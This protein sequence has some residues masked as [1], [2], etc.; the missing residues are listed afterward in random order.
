MVEHFDLDNEEVGGRTIAAIHRAAAEGPIAISCTRARFR[1]RVALQGVTLTQF[2]ASHAIWEKGLHLSQC[3]L[4]GDTRLNGVRA[5]HLEVFDSRFQRPVYA[6]HLQLGTLVLEGATFDAYAA[7]DHMV[8]KQLALRL[9]TFAAEARFRDA[10]VAREGVLRGVTFRSV[11]SFQRSRWQTLRLVACHMSGPT[12][13]AGAKATRSLELIG[14]RLEDSRT[15]RMEAE[16]ACVVRETTFAQPLALTVIAPQLDASAA[17]F[18]AGLD[19]VVAH[20]A[21][22]DLERAVL[23]GPSLITTQPDGAPARLTSVHGTRAKKLTLRGLDL[24]ECLFARA[25]TLDDVVI[26]GDDQLAKAPRWAPGLERREVLA[27]EVDLRRSREANRRIS[28]PKRWRREE[29]KVPAELPG[30]LAEAYRALRRGR[31]EAKDRP[32]AASFYYGEME[33]RRAAAR[34]LIDRAVLTGYWVLSG[35]GLRASRALFAY[36][37]LVV[38]LTIALARWG[39]EK[40][41]DCL[42]ILAYVLATTT[43]LARPPN[44]LMLDTLGS[45]LQVIA[46]TIGPA[47]LAL[48]ILALRSRVRR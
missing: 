42:D 21:A 11:G 27:D 23:D 1:E 36:S 6:R 30:T 38:L 9:V 25:H 46:R 29:T 45:Y 13:L 10:T 7:F 17:S 18:E 14:C 5:R 12:M 31:E 24:S 3:D 33:M 34:G 19:L 26:S 15:L 47:L 16:G 28:W 35:Y 32:G 20:D 43:V 48:A 40:T 8:V 2:A 37:V 41:A 44:E 22:V 4:R 39:L